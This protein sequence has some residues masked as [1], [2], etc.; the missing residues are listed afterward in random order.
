MTQRA[1]PCIEARAK[2]EP[3]RP[4][5]LHLPLPAPHLSVVPNEDFAG[6]SQ[7]GPY[8]D[9]VAEVDATVGAILDAPGRT[10]LTENPPTPGLLGRYRRQE[11]S[12][13]AR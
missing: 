11:C 5:F 6:H 2:G 7:A 10:Q 12:R 8:S 1:L 9:I 4:F 3:H 13:R